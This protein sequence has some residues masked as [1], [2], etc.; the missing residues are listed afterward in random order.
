MRGK[1]Y[2][3]V[4]VWAGILLLCLGAAAYAHT[5]FATITGTV[6]DP[7]GAVVPNATVTATN[8]ET[9]IKTT[10]KSNEAGIYT[11]AQLN[12]GPTRFRPRR[13]GSRR[14]W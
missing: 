7:T 12:E 5:T 3:Q 10:A 8:T 14:W 9:G 2:L 6:S 13:Q 11:I 1:T 4:L